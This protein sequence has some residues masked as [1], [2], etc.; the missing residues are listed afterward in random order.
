MITTAEK[1]A[2]QKKAQNI[3]PW[4]Y[5]THAKNAASVNVKD[6]IV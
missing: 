4:S 3:T 6:R 2:I 1:K 5:T